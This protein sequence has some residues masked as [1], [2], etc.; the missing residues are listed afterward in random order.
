MDDRKLEL[1]QR[2]KEA[3]IWEGSQWQHVLDEPAPLWVVLEIAV[4]LLE[5]TDP[6]HQPFD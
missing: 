2:L 3:G 5:R 4:R 1:V 6:P